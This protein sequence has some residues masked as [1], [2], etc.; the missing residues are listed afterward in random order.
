M[1]LKIGSKI[2]LL[3][4]V[5]ALIT[6][7]VAVLSF[8][9]TAEVNKE[10]R[11]ISEYYLPIAQHVSQINDHVLKKE[12]YFGRVLLLLEKKKSV[13]FSAPEIELIDKENQEL[14][15]LFGQAQQIL[16]AIK[17]EEDL[18]FNSKEIAT[19]RNSLRELQTEHE[20]LHKLNLQIIDSK[21]SPSS[22]ETHRLI[23]LSHSSKDRYNTVLGNLTG[24]LQSLV[25][26]SAKEVATQESKILQRSVVGSSLA[27]IL[28]LLMAFFITRGLVRPIRELVEG[29]RSV[30]NGD[31]ET[32]VRVSSKDEIGDLTQSF[33]HM[34]AELRVKER[35]K[36]T[37]GKYIDPRIVEQLINESDGGKFQ[38]Q[39]KNMTVLFSDIK[40]FTNISENMTP[41]LLVKVINLYFS[42]MSKSVSQFG[43]V[44]DKYIGDAVMAFWGP[45]FSDEKDHPKL[46]CFAALDK[47]AQ[48]DIF[49]EKVK[50]LF[51]PNQTIPEFDLRI[52][53]AT[54]D[55]IVGNIGSEFAQGYTVLGDTV[56]TGSRLEG[57]NKV[58]GT[59]ILIN[60]QTQEM[61]KNYIETRE[62]DSIQVVGKDEP[63]KIFELIGKKDALDE[64]TL[65]LKSQFKKALQAYRS[66]DW[67][68]ARPLFNDCLQTKPDDSPS[69][70][71]LNRISEFAKNPPEE[72]WNGTWRLTKK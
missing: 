12:V 51:Q 11:E 36:E 23:V 39:K 71:F 25:L 65:R 48:L 50:D 6:F 66:K 14:E 20:T 56:N 18:E 53:I 16:E 64:N 41:D 2:F 26:N 68:Q 27:V 8:Y 38:G 13:A 42:L 44:I 49:R 30:E 67:S 34:V 72:N 40:G 62:I 37:F 57:V 21:N 61:A 19:A 46:A 47:L 70:V 7:S 54:G 52:G 9:H 24:H 55:M 60:E 35:I 4:A 1:R 10:G 58:Y 15:F 31:L 59:R 63:I 5:L 32:Q 3:T 17:D 28:G 45:P 22:D 69:Q 33:N 43:G 29:T